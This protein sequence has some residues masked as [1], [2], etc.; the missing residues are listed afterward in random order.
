MPSTNPGLPAAR[1]EELGLSTA[2]LARLSAAFAAEIDQARLPGAVILIAR[3]GRIAHFEALG[4]RDPDSAA[5]MAPD[6]IFRIYSMTKPIV[7]A[8]AMMLFEEG[9]FLLGDPVAAY[10]PALAKLQVGTERRDPT[11]GETVLDLAPASRAITIQDLLRHTAGFTY[12]FM[13]NGPIQKLYQEHRIDGYRGQSNDEMVAKLG[14]LPL[15]AEP[16]TV[17]AYSVATDVLGRL[18]EVVSGQ[19]LGEFLQERILGPLGMIDTGFSVPETAQTRLAE[20]FP[21]DPDSGQKVALHNVRRPPRFESGGGGLA[22]T[23][24]DYAR[25]LQMSLNGGTLDGER[26]LSRKTVE[27]MTADHLGAIPGMDEGRGPGLGFGLG[28]GV[29][30]QPGIATHQGSK[31]SYFW[32][33]AA[34]TRF[35]VDPAEQLVAILMNQAP[36]RRERYSVLFPNLVYG[37]FDD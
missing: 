31:G 20:P 16:G 1:P 5:A 19:S 34:G 11:S 15:I 32:G 21:I 26:L 13:G 3:H 24:L 36:G 14:Q 8:A 33:G 27:F 7:S 10:L 18:V 9:R 37:C 6:D 23:A 4:R 17:W 12:G 29:R 2:R 35:F 28:Y 30:L 25:F 22:S